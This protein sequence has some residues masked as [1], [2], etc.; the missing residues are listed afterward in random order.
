MERKINYLTTSDKN[1]FFFRAFCVTLQV[2]NGNV[3]VCTH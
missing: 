3:A 1:P 2:E